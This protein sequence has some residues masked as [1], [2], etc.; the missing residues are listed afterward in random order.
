MLGSVQGIEKLAALA[1]IS[2][3]HE[4]KEQMCSEFDSILDYIA[5]VQKVSASSAEQ[6]RS[7][8][9][10]VNVMREDGEPHESGIHTEALLSA[11]PQREG[12]YIRV[13]KIL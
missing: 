8:A 13:K 7:I 5:T 2:L 6:S 4:E 9:A 1:R 3:T 10:T 11:A 12:Q